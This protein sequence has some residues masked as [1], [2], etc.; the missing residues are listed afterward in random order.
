MDGLAADVG[1]WSFYFFSAH[2]NTHYQV[3]L[4]MSG[5]LPPSHLQLFLQL[6]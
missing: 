2:G 6:V 4:T 1:T 3:K 5:P